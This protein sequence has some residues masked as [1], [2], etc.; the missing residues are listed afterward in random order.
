MRH[1]DLKNKAVEKGGG[2]ANKHVHRF[3][4]S[5]AKLTLHNIVN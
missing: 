1:M 3:Y 4:V 5:T 2:T